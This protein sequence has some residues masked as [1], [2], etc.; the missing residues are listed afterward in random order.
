MK[1]I[2]LFLSFAILTLS[3]CENT[4]DIPNPEAPSSETTSISQSVKEAF[5]EALDC[6][7]GSSD[8]YRNW[9]PVTELGENPF[10]PPESKTSYLGFSMV[11]DPN[12]TISSSSLDTTSLSILHL[13]STSALIT[14]ITP[15]NDE[16]SKNLAAVIFNLAGAIKE[17]SL[18]AFPV[19]ADLYDYIMSDQGTRMAYP[20]TLSN[21]GTSAA[22]N[23]SLPSELYSTPSGYVAIEDNGDGRAYVSVFSLAP[24]VK[25]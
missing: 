8:L 16:E 7:E 21:D 1:K 13:D 6:S 10:G 12:S 11:F 9:C 2:L 19:S 3:A 18:K 24:L 15:S 23:A 5:T 4:E 14:D 17:S 22:Y 20:I 25:Q